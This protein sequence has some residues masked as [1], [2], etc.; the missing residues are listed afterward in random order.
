MT[1]LL[2]LDASDNIQAAGVLIGTTLA[3]A[4]GSVGLAVMAI[5]G[6]K[7]V[8]NWIKKLF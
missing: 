2:L 4:L 7:A 5:V 6:L 1:A 3:S 8:Y